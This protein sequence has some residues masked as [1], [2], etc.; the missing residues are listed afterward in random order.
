MLVNLT[1]TPYLAA[2]DALLG[3]PFRVLLGYQGLLG[4]LYHQLAQFVLH[5]TEKK[6]NDDPCLLK[7][8][9]TVAETQ[10]GVILCVE[11]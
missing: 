5:N 10:V 8:R 11:N 7:I 1:S 3:R 6:N 4:I 9:Q 2:Q